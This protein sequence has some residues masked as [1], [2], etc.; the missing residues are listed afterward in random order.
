M[1]ELLPKGTIDKNKLLLFLT[2]WVDKISQ[3]CMFSQGQLRMWT[4]PHLKAGS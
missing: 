2:T 4:L 3:H 1:K